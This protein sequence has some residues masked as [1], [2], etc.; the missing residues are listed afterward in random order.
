MDE[1]ERPVDLCKWC[2][3]DI[4]FDGFSWRHVFSRSRTCPDGSPATRHGAERQS[5]FLA[6]LR[7]TV[8][9]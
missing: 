8:A 4:E 6:P 7:G 5:R 2:A 1:S 9:T 3:E